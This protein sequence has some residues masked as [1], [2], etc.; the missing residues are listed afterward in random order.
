MIKVVL[1]MKN[2]TKNV[3]RRMNVL[4]PD[5]ESAPKYIRFK[6]DLKPRPPRYF[7]KLPFLYNDLPVYYEIEFNPL[8]YDWP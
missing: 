2:W 5:I 3:K 7:E 6:T 8:P 4:A 1:L